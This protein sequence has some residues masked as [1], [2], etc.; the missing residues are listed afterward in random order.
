M[1]VFALAVV[2]ADGTIEGLG[3]TGRG[4][5]GL[6]LRVVITTGT[7]REDVALDVVA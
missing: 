7:Q 5:A 6:A 1:V 4:Y 3:G 2:S